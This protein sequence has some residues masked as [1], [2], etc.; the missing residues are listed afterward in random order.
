MNINI[1]WEGLR[2]QYDYFDR[3]APEILKAIQTA[4]VENGFFI[5]GEA[6]P[7]TPL[8][9]GFLRGSYMVLLEED[10][11]AESRRTNGGRASINITSTEYKRTTRTSRKL[12]VTVGTNQ[13]YAYYQHE[14]D[15]NHTDGEKEF[16]KKAIQQNVRK[17]H[18]NVADAI[19]EV[20]RRGGR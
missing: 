8:D 14:G 12:T 10:K 18:E 19:E 2:Q 20:L 13:F 7:K 5:M 15:F 4:I 11:M 1:N 9:E 16:L 17:L 3:L 6:I